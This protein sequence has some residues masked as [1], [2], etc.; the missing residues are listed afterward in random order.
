MTLAKDIMAFCMFLCMFVVLIL[1]I[2][3]QAELRTSIVEHDVIITA[4]V[5][6]IEEDMIMLRKQ[7]HKIDSLKIEILDLNDLLLILQ[8]ENQLLREAQDATN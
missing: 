5:G 4:Q 3:L 7:D 2:Q 6:V 1:F 8:R